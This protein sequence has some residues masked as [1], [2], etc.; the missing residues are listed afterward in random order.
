MRSYPEI[1]DATKQISKGTECRPHFRHTSVALSPSSSFECPCEMMGLGL[2]LGL[3]LGFGGRGQTLSAKNCGAVYCK[4]SLQCK[5]CQSWLTGRQKGGARGRQD[6]RTKGREPATPLSLLCLLSCLII[7]CE[8]CLHTFR[9]SVTLMKSRRAGDGD[10][11]RPR[12]S[13]HFLPPA[14]HPLF[15]HFFAIYS[16]SSGLWQS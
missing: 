11:N 16:M 13:P 15:L 9:L 3:G 7:K 12:P 8:K 14:L 6:A 2:G 5:C 1:R 4:S 10:A